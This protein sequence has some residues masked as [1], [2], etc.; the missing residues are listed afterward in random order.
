MSKLI[1][2][3]TAAGLTATLYTVVPSPLDTMDPREF[4]RQAGVSNLVYDCAEKVLE[5][6]S[7]DELVLFIE[8][9]AATAGTP[10][11]TPTAAALKECVMLDPLGWAGTD[12]EQH[13]PLLQEYVRGGK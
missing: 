10:E 1:G 2:M 7:V 6:K 8:N 13:I 11:E 3:L 5:G 9:E 4:A 12:M